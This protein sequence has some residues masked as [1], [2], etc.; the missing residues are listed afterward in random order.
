MEESKLN[1]RGFIKTSVGGAA[2]L[3]L[4]LKSNNLFA[5][6]ETL[7]LPFCTLTM[8]IAELMLSQWTE[9]ETLEKVEWPP[10]PL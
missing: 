3:A 4:G 9:V 2:L 1:R 10:G 8:Y 6:D 5:A 7:N